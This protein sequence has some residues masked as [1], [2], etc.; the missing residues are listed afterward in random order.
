MN[1][2]TYSLIFWA[3]WQQESSR[4]NKWRVNSL[5][6]PP[7]KH[8]VGAALHSAPDIPVVMMCSSHIIPG[9]AAPPD[10]PPNQNHLT[11]F[12]FPAEKTLEESVDARLRE[13]VLQSD[14]GQEA[15]TSGKGVLYLGFGS[16]PAPDPKALLQLAV[17]VSKGTG[18]LLNSLF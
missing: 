18:G 7:L 5:G 4:I 13:F 14:H 12:A 16:M 6:L 17:Q 15:A 8:G 11:G 1:K 3:L 9:L 10:W 2:A